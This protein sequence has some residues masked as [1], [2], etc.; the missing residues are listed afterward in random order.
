MILRRALSVEA[1]KSRIQRA[2]SNVLTH[3][4]EAACH[5][6]TANQSVWGIAFPGGKY[7]TPRAAAICVAMKNVPLDHQIRPRGAFEP[8]SVAIEA[9]DV[10]IVEQMNKQVEE[11]VVARRAVSWGARPARAHG[12]EKLGR[13]ISRVGK[14][15]GISSNGREAGVNRG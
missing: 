8:F 10:P 7:Q 9:L 12:A 15:E 3:P 11:V 13:D 6:T 2:Y 4:I 1:E 14:S 5:R